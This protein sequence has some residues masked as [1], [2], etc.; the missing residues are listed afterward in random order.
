MIGISRGWKVGLVIGFRISMRKAQMSEIRIFWNRATVSR[1][2]DVD[3][4]GPHPGE[5]LL[6][7]LLFLA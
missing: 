5:S 4:K 7:L 1:G 3:T 2:Q 6:L